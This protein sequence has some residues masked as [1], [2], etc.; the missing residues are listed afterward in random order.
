[1]P[2]PFMLGWLLCLMAATLLGA[3][4][5]SPPLDRH[6]GLARWPDVSESELRALEMQDLLSARAHT[7]IGSREKS[8]NR[9]AQA[10]CPVLASSRRAK[11]DAWPSFARHAPQPV[12]WPGVARPSESAAG[13]F[14]GF[15]SGQI[16]QSRC[17]HCHVEG[18][19]SGHTRLVLTPSTETDHE[20]LN[21]ET[22]RKFVESVEDGADR[23]LNKIQGVGHG[24]GVQV[25]AGT[26]DFANM[27]RFLRLLDGGISTIGPS[28]ETLFDGVTMA[29]PEKTL[30]RAALI[31]AG[32]LPTQ[33]EIGSVSDGR[34]SSLRRAIR[35]L[36][37]GPG[38]HDFLIR[39]SNDRLLTDR[40]MDDQIFDIDN[41]VFFVK[42]ANTQLSLAKAAID[43]GYTSENSDPAYKEWFDSLLYGF[44]RAP[45]ELIAHVVENDLP[46]TEIV[47]AD[48]IMA[49]PVV[50]GA[51]G[52]ETR[53][54]NPRDPEEFKP[55]RIV[56][57]YRDDDSKVVIRFNQEPLDGRWIVNPGNLATD[58]PHAGILN[59]TVFLARYPTTATNRN[60]AR[61]R[62]T[63]YHFLAVDIE[64]SASRTTNAA[65]LADTNNPTMNNPACTVCHRV[66]DP[67]AGAFQNYGEQGFYRDEPGGL[68]SLAGLYKVPVD[69]SES[70]YQRG[71]A[72]YRDM[73][74]PGFGSELAP[75]ADNSLQWLARKIAADPRFAEA[76]VRF[77]WPGVLGEEVV[78]P[79]EDESDTDF[80]GQLLVSQA[81]AAE[82]KRLAESFRNG[83]AGG[84]PFNARDLLT[85]IALS[86]WFLA[87][88]LAAGDPVREAAL[89]HAGVERLLTPEELARKTEALTGYVWGRRPR[90]WPGG[91]R[92]N[93]DA[94]NPRDSA[95]ELTYGGMDSDSVP[96]RTGGMTPMMAAVAQSHAVESVVLSWDASSLSGRRSAGGCSAG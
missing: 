29:K 73:R 50:A 82:V 42:M 79:P 71:D 49:N 16:V 23:I 26:A 60:R 68:D 3:P 78:P 95:Y 40:F 92:S 48:Y 38:F 15:V 88:S 80:A 84:R 17:I 70:P 66:M 69:G 64:K 13:I 28:P 30:R 4:F 43:R 1:M 57:Y 93:L 6:P 5:E 20:T 44:A 31:F 21:L 81:Q 91:G 59:T 19:V 75:S 32:R 35:R 18:G 10:S 9:G 85:E 34:T 72:W 58:Y 36:M 53:F 74:D 37:K 56:S 65:A 87:E 52:A 67:V 90:K 77:W 14:E 8:S 76:A 12:R 47:T 27:E 83:I 25:P 89:R 62:W 24:G 22:F 86:P 2:R 55:S 46:Y 94:A 63:Y 61:S 39:A 11:T 41:D 51:Y 96:T 7:R 45:L 54:D 33:A